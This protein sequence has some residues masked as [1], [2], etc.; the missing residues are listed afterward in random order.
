ME[1]MSLARARRQLDRRTNLPVLFSSN[2]QKYK[3]SL[4]FLSSLLHLAPP[5]LPKLRPLAPAMSG[6]FRVFKKVANQVNRDDA[7]TMATQVILNNGIRMPRIGLGTF[8]LK[9]Q[10]LCLKL[11]SEAITSGYRLFDTGTLVGNEQFIGD[12]VY[13]KLNS[14]ELK[15]D[16]IF[17]E[18]KVAPWEHGKQATST[19]VSESLKRLKLSYLDLVLVHWPGV[20]K[21]PPG[22]PKNKSMRAET[23]RE[24]ESLV[25]QGK[26]KSIG[27]SNYTESHLT[28]LL[29]YCKLKPVL[30]QV[31]FH[32]LC[33]Q[34]KLLQFCKDNSIYLQAYSSLGSSQGKP[35]G[36]TVLF[37]ND[38]VKSLATKHK[39]T[40]PQILLRW[41][42]QHDCLL[43]PKTSR[44]ENLEPNLQIFDF[45]LD[46]EDMVKLNELNQDKHFCWNPTQ[47]M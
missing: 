6:L 39:R 34:R 40:V 31:E 25:E 26:I 17:I 43:I 11:F 42:L 32:P 18:T 3:H 35:P 28:D 29:S 33:Y 38:V 15:R 45:N 5:K 4:C 36:W 30:N 24:L 37:N 16:D 20:A 8:G 23:W 27:V 10:A 22:D 12:V 21:T 1:Q 47:I 7:S 41:G 2:K 19:A 14:Q 9:D 44:S 13:D 46:A